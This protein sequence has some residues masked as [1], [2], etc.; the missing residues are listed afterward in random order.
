MGARTL[1]A[2]HGLP[3]LHWMT[4]RPPWQDRSPWYPSATL[5]RRRAGTWGDVIARIVADQEA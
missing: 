1:V 5:Y 4:D 2:L 3:N